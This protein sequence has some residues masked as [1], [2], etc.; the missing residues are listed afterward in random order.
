MEIKVIQMEPF[1]PSVHPLHIDPTGPIEAVGPGLILQRASKFPN[2]PVELIVYDRETGER[3]KIVI[4][5]ERRTHGERRISEEPVK[6]NNHRRETDKKAAPGP[7]APLSPKA[8]PAP[9]PVKKV[10]PAPKVVPSPTPA[11]TPPVVPQPVVK[12]P[13]PA[14]PKL[15]PKPSPKL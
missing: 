9:Q 1:D 13:T 15:S 2:L 4:E 6:E 12:S 10:A 8:S 11:K 7:A 14:S 3:Q 5:I